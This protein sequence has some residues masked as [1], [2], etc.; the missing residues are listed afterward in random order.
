MGVLQ[1][2]ALD[3]WNRL[4][5]SNLRRVEPGDRIV[6]INAAC[7]PAAMRRECEEKLLLHI[8]M[9]PGT[10]RKAPKSQQIHL[11]PMLPAP[12]MHP[13]VHKTSHLGRWPGIEMGNFVFAP[14]VGI[15][16]DQSWM[17]EGPITPRSKFS[18]DESTFLGSPS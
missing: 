18:D 12:F 11:A 2:G 9:V 16:S 15:S 5:S 3:S 17:M 4:C 7:T 1:G 14:A 6:K 13:F 8:R 10:M